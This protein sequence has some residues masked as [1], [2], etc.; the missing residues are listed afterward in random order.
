ML[1][2]SRTHFELEILRISTGQA[3]TFS[4]LTGSVTPWVA[5]F[6]GTLSGDTPGT[7]VPATNGYGRVNSAGK[8]ATPSAGSVSNN[9]TISF[10]TATGSWA[11]GAPITH[12][13]IFDAATGG[14]ALYYGALSDQ[15]KTFGTGDQAVFS[16]GTLVLSE[17]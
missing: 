2:P 6:T 5:L 7:E 8:W 17:D 9:A 10:T 15:T 11:S 16:S 12:F 3:A 13:A 14:N 4:G 1:C